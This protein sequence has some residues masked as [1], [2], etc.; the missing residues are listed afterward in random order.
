MCKASEA[1]YEPSTEGRETIVSTEGA[2]ARAKATRRKIDEERH[3]VGE[4]SRITRREFMLRSA[5]VAAIAAIGAGNLAACGGGAQQQTGSAGGTER[6]QILRFA[7]TDIRGLEDL[8]RDWEPFQRELAEITGV[9]A[10][11]YPVPNPLAATEAMNAGRLELALAGAS[12][13]V[14]MR[15][16]LG[17][18]P[19]IGVARRDYFIQMRVHEDSEIESV[20]QLR[21]KRIDAGSPG[22]TQHVAIAQILADNGLDP[23]SDVE[24]LFAAQGE[25]GPFFEGEIDA[26]GL[27]PPFWEFSFEEAGVSEDRFPV[28][29]EGPELPP[30]LIVASPDLPEGFRR[31]L[32]DSIVANEERFIEAILSGESGENE[33][34]AGADVRPVEDSD[35]D[36]IRKAYRTIGQEDFSELVDG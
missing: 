5:G 33:K 30:D 22:G 10:E 3:L 4:R 11:L 20:E 18:I 2:A 28:I 7:V 6:P 9:E 19:L 14:A 27:T 31:E 26:T 13:Y 12:E 17:A 21:G 32:R 15:D 36:Y 34:F 35:Y 24:F 23:E 1:V 8:Q 25:I 29:A 16:V